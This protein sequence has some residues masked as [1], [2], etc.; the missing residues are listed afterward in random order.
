MSK[1]ASFALSLLAVLT[2]MGSLSAQEY[3]PLVQQDVISVV[4]VNLDKVDPTQLGAQAQKLGGAAIDYF[5]ADLENKDEIKQALPIATIFISQYHTDFIKPLQAAGVS[6]LYII[7]STQKGDETVYP[8][9]AIPTKELS[10]SQVEQVR[11]HMKK[12]N[13]K[14]DDA[15]SY[16]FSRNGFFFM[17]IIP[18]SVSKDDA[19]AYV[20]EHFGSM[21]AVDSAAF[22]AGF[23]AVDADN[24][25]VSC[26]SLSNKDPQLLTEQKEKLLQLMK[27]L[28]DGD[29]SDSDDD[30]L[31]VAAKDLVQFTADFAEKAANLAEYNAWA[32]NVDDLYI[33]SIIKAT[34]EDAAKEYV[35]LVEGE[36]TDKLKNF[37]DVCERK[38]VASI[39]PDDANDPTELNEEDVKTL[40]SSV[41]EIFPLIMKFDVQGDSL[42]WKLDEKFFKDNETALKDFAKKIADVFKKVQANASDEI[43]DELNDA[44]DD[45]M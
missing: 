44:D 20:K 16:R 12:V 5:A 30:E 19:K 22:E 26:V 42:A 33:V 40:V 28:D 25:V 18:E 15:I 13:Q 45:D 3:A 27:D 24:V 11:S 31:E 10:E 36:L 4:R 14:V 17:P 23:K 39:E 43:N 21:K 34:S 38:A 29:D 9:V 1:F 2:M 8:Y 41:K 7:A 32:I 37:L 6:N 35:A